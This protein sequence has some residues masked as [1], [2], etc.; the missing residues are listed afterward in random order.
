MSTRDFEAFIR[1]VLPAKTVVVWSGWLFQT[2]PIKWPS[3]C[4]V[5]IKKYNLALGSLTKNKI[6][7]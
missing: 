6:L 1:D 4:C 2:S 5:Q 3:T 7:N